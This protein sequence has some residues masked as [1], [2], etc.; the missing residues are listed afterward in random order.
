MAEKATMPQ[1]LNYNRLSQWAL[2][3]FLG[4][5]QKCQEKNIFES[6]SEC[7]FGALSMFIP[8]R[9]CRPSLPLTNGVTI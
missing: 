1:S 4:G 3:K 2:R 9:N 8:G 6:W 7:C 5:P